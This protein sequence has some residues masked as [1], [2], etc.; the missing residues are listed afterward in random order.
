MK[1]R[2]FLAV[3]LMIGIIGAQNAAVSNLESGYLYV[4]P[5]YAED[6]WKK[7]FDD[8]CSKTDNAAGL[9]KEEL[10]NLIDR[11]D[12]LK[13]VIEKLDESTRKVY[14]RRLQMCRDLFSFVL[15][16]KENN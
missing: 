13:A 7:E 5:A 11:C 1:M 10:K 8:V 2:I 6:A 16:S 4:K 3:I 12:K 14:L 15:E 9:A